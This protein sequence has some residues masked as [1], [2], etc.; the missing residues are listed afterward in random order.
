MLSYLGITG[1][2]LGAWY[3]F[4][5]WKLPVGPSRILAFHSVSD[6]M[7]LGISRNSL[8]GFERIISF[9]AESKFAGGKISGRLKESDIALTFDDG[10][11]DFYQNAFPILR[12]YRFSATI[13]VVTNYIGKN[14]AWD[15][16][17]KRHLDWRQIQE[18]SDSGIE[19]GSHSASHR[20]LRNLNDR[21]LDNEL[22]G[23]KAILEDKL[24]LPIRYLSYPFGRYNNKVIEC[25]AKTGYQNAY[26]M[27]SGMGNFAVP[28]HCVY[29]YDSPYSVNLKLNGSVIETCKEYVNNS[30]AGGTI[31]LKRLFPTKL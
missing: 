20:D 4:G 3:A 26:A 15:Y 29:L 23:S 12:K 21:E 22:A 25:A 16:Q 5:K 30:L 6:K 10:W 28:R 27:V 11:L 13:F 17:K 2:Y 14:S 19:F 8:L 18:L 7:G 9:L 24:G 31:T 1:A